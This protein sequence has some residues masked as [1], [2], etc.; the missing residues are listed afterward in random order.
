[1][2]LEAAVVHIDGADKGGLAVRQHGLPM[3]KAG[4]ER[5]DL[6]AVAHQL[7]PIALGHQIGQLMVGDAGHQQTGTHT[8]VRRQTQRTHHR[9]VDGQ[10]GRGDGQ[11]FAGA[12]DELQKGI[13]GVID[14]V[15]VRAVHKGLDKPL[16]L[17]VETGTVITT[18]MI[19]RAAHA[20]PQVDEFPGQRP[21]P[22]P[23]QAHAAVLPVAKALH[24]VAILVRQIGA[25]GIGDLAVDAGDLAMVAVV[26]VEPI[27]ILMHRIE[28]HDL[29]ANLPQGVHLLVA[30]AHHA[31]EI[32]KEETDLHALRPLA[33]ENGQHPV[34]QLAAGHNVIFQKD[35]PLRLLHMGQQVVEI[36]LAG[37]QIHSVGAAVKRKTLTGHIAGKAA[38][39]RKLPL[40]LRLRGGAAGDLGCALRRFGPFLQRKTLGAALAVPEPVEDQARHRNRQHQ[41][42]PADLIAGAAGAGIDP[43]GHKQ[44]NDLHQ[45]IAKRHTLLQQQRKTHH[46]RDLHHQQQSHQR[47]PQ[48]RADAPLRFLLYAVFFHTVPFGGSDP[49]AACGR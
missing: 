20:L 21:C 35:K 36:G 14:G 28:D 6:H 32:I 44:A 47:K 33:A 37:I 7:A 27:H 2:E 49:S 15:I 10:I 40:Y 43:H 42:D 11:R 25:A 17:P 16:P 26:E 46:Q 18:G 23:C 31:A 8:A 9:L 22:L 24:P 48:A 12:A 41:Q 45:Q 3:K 34:K 30:K 19:Q 39:L 4:G 1:M 13:L 38:P 5:I 29:H